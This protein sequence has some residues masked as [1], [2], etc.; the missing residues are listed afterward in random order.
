VLG[1]LDGLAGGVVAGGVGG[2][3]DGG[4][5]VGGEVGPFGGFG[6]PSLTNTLIVEPIGA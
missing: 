3:E 6:V 5:D 1:E 2:V 4:G